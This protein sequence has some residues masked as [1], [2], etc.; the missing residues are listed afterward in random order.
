MRIDFLGI[1][2]RFK[3]Q[4][5]WI[6]WRVLDIKIELLKRG[7]KSLGRQTDKS[8]DQLE[9]AK[10]IAGELGAADAEVKFIHEKAL[11]TS[12]G[13]ALTTWARMEDSLIAIAG[14]LLK[15]NLHTPV[16]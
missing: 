6:S 11:F 9:Q 7:V 3:W 1:R 10:A 14:M 16:W 5:Q 2:R 8:P 12:I 4:V 13:I 15:K